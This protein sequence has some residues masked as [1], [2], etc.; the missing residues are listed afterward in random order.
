MEASTLEGPIRAGRTPANNDIDLAFAMLEWHHL[1]DHHREADMNLNALRNFIA[2]VEAGA[3]REAA[4]TLHLAQSALSRQILA[5]EREF[6]AQLLERLPRG[7]V[8]TPAGRVVLRHARLTLDQMNGARE[9]IAAFAGLRTGQI[10]IGAIEPFASGPL[11]ACISRFQARYPGIGVEA[12]VGNSRQVARLVQEGIVELGIAYN[13]PRAEGLAVRAA[14]RQP[15]VALV[16]P[17]HDLAEQDAVRLAD[18]AGARLILPPAGS[19]TRLLIEEA[20]RR[21]RLILEQ[22][23]LESDSVALRLAVAA[24]T[25]GVAI[26]AHLSGVAACAA[27]TLTMRPLADPLLGAG[28]LELLCGTGRTLSKATAAFERRLRTALKAV[29]QPPP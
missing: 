23:A 26:L 15:L 27:G 1:E 19:P 16:R 18:L 13:A 20:A 11:A 22:V 24:R 21:A 5:L 6:G 8:P 7:V 12:R 29:D 17:G 9:E 3:I 4:D 14:A 2:V 28:Q 10:R 25:E